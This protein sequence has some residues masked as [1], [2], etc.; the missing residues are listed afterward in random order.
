MK[1]C[2]CARDGCGCGCGQACVF[3]LTGHE[4]SLRLPRRRPSLWRWVPSLISRAWEAQPKQLNSV[5]L[6]RRVVSEQSLTFCCGWLCAR[7]KRPGP[8][9]QKEHQTDWSPVPCQ[10][11]FPRT[12]LGGCRERLGSVFIRLRSTEGNRVEDQSGLSLPVLS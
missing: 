7:R 4:F 2:G 1:P 8:H 12:V 9:P 6:L 5:Q 11:L 3:S 10:A